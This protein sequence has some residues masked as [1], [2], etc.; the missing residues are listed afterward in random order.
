MPLEAVDK[1][2]DNLDSNIVDFLLSIKSASTYLLIAC[3]KQIKFPLFE[4]Y[5]I[6]EVSDNI[7]GKYNFNIVKKSVWYFTSKALLV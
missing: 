7:I 4:L 2:P 6:S 3:G 5:C 1:T